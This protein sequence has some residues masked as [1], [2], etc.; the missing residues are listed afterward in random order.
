MGANKL[1]VVGIFR[2]ESVLLL[3]SWTPAP[4]PF[5]HDQE[6]AALHPSG[7]W[8][9]SLC[10]RICAG[11]ARTHLKA[12]KKYLDTKEARGALISPLQS[13]HLSPTKHLRRDL[14]TLS[15]HYGLSGCSP[16]CKHASSNGGGQLFFFATIYGYFSAAEYFLK[17]LNKYKMEVSSLEIS[18]FGPCDSLRTRSTKTPL[19]FSLHN[20]SDLG[21][22]G[23]LNV[24][25][26]MKRLS[27]KDQAEVRRGSWEI[28]KNL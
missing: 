27:F 20:F 28:N 2:S 26:F 6:E 17:V 1:V 7:L 13:L 10:R 21:P 12:L 8:F 18:D 23:T 3:L 16:L 24:Q 19:P 25:C 15:D 22:C 11:K 9:A 5:H 14:E 4:N